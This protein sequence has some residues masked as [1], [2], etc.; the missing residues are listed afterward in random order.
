MQKGCWDVLVSALP[1][2][3]LPGSQRRPIAFKKDRL[4]T[5]VCSIDIVP[6]VP[7][8]LPEPVNPEGS[9]IGCSDA[10]GL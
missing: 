8:S 9:C 2:Q 5:R 10:A 6:C 3:R 7:H 4:D 1:P